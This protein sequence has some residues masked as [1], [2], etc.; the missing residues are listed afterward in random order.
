MYK[1]DQKEDKTASNLCH[2][3]F[4]WFI[5]FGIYPILSLLEKKIFQN[6][7]LNS[8]MHNKDITVNPFF[9]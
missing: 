5:N 7:Q 9:K 1:S 3:S 2:R 8:Q 4:V 6:E